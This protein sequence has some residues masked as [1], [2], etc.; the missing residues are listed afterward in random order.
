M[1]LRLKL[2]RQ[3]SFDIFR[4]FGLALALILDLCSCQHARYTILM[5][6]MISIMKSD[7]NDHDHHD[8]NYIK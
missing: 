8:I 2:F 6:I 4:W 1:L 5:I 7:N 3:F